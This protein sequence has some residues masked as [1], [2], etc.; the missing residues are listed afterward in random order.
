MKKEADCDD[1]IIPAM[2]TMQCGKLRGKKL[3]AEGKKKVK[4]WRDGAVRVNLWTMTRA[5]VYLSS[6]IDHHLKQEER[7]RETRVEF[8]TLL[9]EET[10]TQRQPDAGE[11]CG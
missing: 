2:Y 7:G 11:G 8:N 10:T 6:P 4:K 5:C 1:Y 9:H 3:M